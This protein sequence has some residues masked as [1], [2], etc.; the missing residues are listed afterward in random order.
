MTLSNIDDETP[1]ILVSAI[2]SYTIE[3]GDSA[4]FT[5]K[6]QNQPTENVTVSL[7]SSDPTEGDV[8]PDSLTFTGGNWN[9]DQIVT[10]TGVDDTTTDGHQNYQIQVVATLAS[11]ASYESLDPV[12]MSVTN[13]DDEI[14]EFLIS[15]ISAHTT[16]G[17]GT[18][19]FTMRLLKKPTLSVSIDVSSD[20]ATEGSKIGYDQANNIKSL[21][22][23][24]QNEPLLALY[25]DF[26]GQKENYENILENIF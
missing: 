14:S 2:S 8:S 10:V 25:L 26:L 16:E 20:D 9:F 19:T 3:Y 6:L 15:P 21:K 13:L 12:D 1:G 18:A 17:G 24:S 4:T 5:V 22:H 23:S 7:S 11:G